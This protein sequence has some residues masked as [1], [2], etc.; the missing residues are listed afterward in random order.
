MNTTYAVCFI[1]VA[2]GLLASLMRGSRR[3]EATEV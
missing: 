1:L 2:A 3:G